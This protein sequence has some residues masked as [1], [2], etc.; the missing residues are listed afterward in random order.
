MLHVSMS[1]QCESIKVKI[2]GSSG[3]LGAIQR[4]LKQAQITLQDM[5]K[6]EG[7]TAIIHTLPPGSDAEVYVDMSGDFPTFVFSMPQYNSFEIIDG[8]SASDC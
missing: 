1:E 7:A 6:W 8:G 3:D 4:M 2:G 5:N